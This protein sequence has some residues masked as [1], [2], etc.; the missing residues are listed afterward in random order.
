[1]QRAVILFIAFIILCFSHEANCQYLPIGV[2]PMEYNPSFAGSVDD[3]RII[4]DLRYSDYKKS[5]TG[6]GMG[7]AISA[8]KF[9]SK[10]KSGIGFV[11]KGYKE[12][13]LDPGIDNYRYGNFSLIFAPKFS[14]KGKYTISPSIDI[15][16]SCINFGADFPYNDNSKFMGFSGNI[17]LL[18]NT[19]NYY[20]GY[21]L[22]VF[23]SDDLKNIYSE[24]LYSAIQAGYSFIKVDSKFCFT[25]QIAIPII[26][27]ED[28][29]ILWPSYNLG[30]RYDK[31]LFA[32]LSQFD[33]AY[34]T[35]FQLG[36][37][38]KGWRYLISNDFAGGYAANLTIRY[39][40]NHDKKSLNILY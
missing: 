22:R 18:I 38:K 5:L 31:L 30:L 7:L 34:P 32:A 24:K 33:Y 39:I 10:I 35:G 9:I 23:K 29:S 27:N 3:T 20:F 15:K 4:G 11:A 1:M 17:G 13:P 6:A 19:Q 21:A 26:G 28:I 40:F 25:P 16:Y 37:Q 2:L 14:L 36:W 8:D 12:L